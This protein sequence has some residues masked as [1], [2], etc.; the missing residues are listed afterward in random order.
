MDGQGRDETIMASVANQNAENIQ[1]K[2]P[3]KEPQ[4]PPAKDALETKARELADSLAMLNATLESAMDAI[5]VTDGT[6]KVLVCNQNF[7]NMW[8]IPRQVMDTRDYQRIFEVISR[9]SNTPGVFHARIEEIWRTS[10]P[11]SH[12]VLELQD[13]RVIEL[14]SKSQ[15]VGDRN[16]GRVWSARDITERNRLEKSRFHL[17]SIVESSDDAIVSKTLDGIVTSWNIG[18]EH[19]FGY[20][21]E[22]MIGKPIATLIPANHVDE[23]PDILKRLRAGERISHYETVRMRK[24]GTL[25]NVSLTV[26]PIRNSEGTI[27]GASKIARDITDLKRAIEEREYFLTAER[28]ARSEAERISLMKDEF[29]ANVSHELRTPL[30]AIL[31]WAQLLVSTP[32]SSDDF[33]EGVATIERN[34][35]LGWAQLLV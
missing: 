16:I 4:I 15:F 30:N 2:F 19:M 11:D 1:P 31:G 6:G 3:P 5:L 29:L 22:E 20:T 25:L 9:Q 24:D 35:I 13:D 32:P 7:V 27:I 33:K 26:S 10:P 17:A 21:A 28:A 8:R 34:A 18:A 23:E 12:D 14:F